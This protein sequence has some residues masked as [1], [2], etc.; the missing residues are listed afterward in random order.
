MQGGARSSE[1]NLEERAISREEETEDLRSLSRNSSQSSLSES[2]KSCMTKPGRKIGREERGP[3]GSSSSSSSATCS[4][5]REMSVGRE[6]ESRAEEEKTT[7]KVSEV[8]KR[9]DEEE[10]REQE[11]QEGE[12]EDENHL[13]VSCTAA[14]YFTPAE[15]QVPEKQAEERYTIT[16]QPKG[17]FQKL[18]RHPKAFRIFPNQF[19]FRRKGISPKKSQDTPIQVGGGSA[20]AEK[21]LLLLFVNFDPGANVRQT[22]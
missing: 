17:Y 8:R 20:C 18:P 11:E 15:R 13:L 1:G 10:V 14:S 5:L 3:S 7:E 16:Y 2:R 22:L 9:E 21:S 19:K 6:L 4:N 12:L